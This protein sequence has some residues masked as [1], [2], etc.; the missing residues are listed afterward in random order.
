MTALWA[1][2]VSTKIG[3]WIVGITLVIGGLA[4]ALF[5][6]FLK[7]K[8][9]QADADKAKDAEASQQA[10]KEAAAAVQQSADAV[11]ATNDEISK[12]PDAGTQR[13]GDAVAGP[14]EWL[15]DNANRDKAGS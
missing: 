7:G 6:A 2:F 4:A 14:A 1:W 11:R 13:V 5:V 10:V 15:R 9:H 3:R 12:M 8:E